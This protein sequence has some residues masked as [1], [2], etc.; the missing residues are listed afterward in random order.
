MYQN[1]RCGGLFKNGKDGRPYYIDAIVKRTQTG[2][3]YSGSFWLSR[4][5]YLTGDRDKMIRNTQYIKGFPFTPKTFYVDV[6][7]EEVKPD[8][9]EMYIKDKKQLNEVYNYYHHIS[10]EK[11][12]E[13][14]LYGH[15]NL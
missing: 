15:K 14:I 8:D 5:D 12:L 3:C 1:N 10:R 6:I 2:S 7:E 4:K 13:R 9:W 11:K